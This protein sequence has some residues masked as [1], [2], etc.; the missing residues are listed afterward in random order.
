MNGV[1][2]YK[3][4]TDNHLLLYLKIKTNNMKKCKIIKHEVKLCL[5]KLSSLKMY[6]PNQHITYTAG[7]PKYWVELS[8]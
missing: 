5:I 3:G 2:I 7:F 8:V 1:V 4:H 6:L